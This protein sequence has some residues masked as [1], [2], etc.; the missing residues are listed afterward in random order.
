MD[1]QTFDKTI[2][3]SIVTGGIVV[4]MYGVLEISLKF[5]FTHTLSF[6][7][8]R[9]D[10]LTTTFAGLT[11]SIIGLFYGIITLR[12]KHVTI[13]HVWQKNRESLIWYSLS[14]IDNEVIFMSG[15]FTYLG[16]QNFDF[17]QETAYVEIE[18][19]NLINPLAIQGQIDRLPSFSNALGF[20]DHRQF[21]AIIDYLAYSL[22]FI[23]NLENGDYQSYLLVLRAEKA[24]EILDLFP[25]EV[26]K[27][28]G[29][30]EW[31]EYFES[32]DS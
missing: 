13:E 14:T 17:N 8:Y 22:G 31:K 29:L 3:L 24:R 27:H 11:V 2:M 5:M 30:K 32:I 12:K 15:V 28:K 6:E 10:T 7:D 25:D 16:W 4:A 9:N 1:K 21:I 26:S 23:K 18:K 20:M 19:T